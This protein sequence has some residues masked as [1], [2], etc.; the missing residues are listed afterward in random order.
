MSGPGG[1]GIV[2][3]TGSAV[4]KWAAAGKTIFLWLAK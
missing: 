3:G 4:G 2:D 1:Q